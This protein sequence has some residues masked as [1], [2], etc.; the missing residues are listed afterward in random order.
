MRRG[1]LA[2]QH[3]HRLRA[4]GFA[5]KRLEVARQ[6]QRAALLTAIEHVH[7]GL[8]RRRELESGRES[9]DDQPQ[10]GEAAPEAGIGIE[11]SEM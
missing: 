3:V 9:V 1:R 10:A 2:Q 8:G 7:A 5:L 11:E 6:P 4:P